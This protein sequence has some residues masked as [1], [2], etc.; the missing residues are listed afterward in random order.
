M[1]KLS[2]LLVVFVVFAFI[3]V[4]SAPAQTKKS[5]EL[6]KT[7][8]NSIGMKFVLIPAGTFTMG[9][10]YS[11]AS[12]DEK[13]QHSVT[14]TK[15]FYMGVYEVTQGQWEAVTGNNPAHFN[16][17][18]PGVT[19]SSNHPVE[20][21]SWEDAQ[22]Y[23]MALTDMDGRSYRLPT[24]AEWEYA[25]RAG[26]TTIYPGGNYAEKLGDY[27]WYIKNS[28][29]KTHPVGQKLPNAWGLYDM[30]GNASE[31]V[32]DWFTLYTA[33][34]VSDPSGR[35]TGDYRVIRGGCWDCQA[36]SCLAAFRSG[37][38]RPSYSSNFLGLRLV[39]E[40]KE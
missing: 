21:V 29:K 2:I 40:I 25:A 4:E 19:D 34:S 20:T 7:I 24:E 37:I 28:D 6:P 22:A 39:I 17:E 12:D 23:A 15:P 18:R 13:P 14:I 33:D 38:G 1:K 11:E 5:S 9:S 3:R 30:H 26:S 35:Q 10:A 8:T 36:V 31:W 16:A 27:A 32:Q